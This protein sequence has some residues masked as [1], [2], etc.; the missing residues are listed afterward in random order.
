MQCEAN[1]TQKMNEKTR[2][3]RWKNENF[4]GADGRKWWCRQKT[5]WL[6]NEETKETEIKNIKEEA[7][8]DIE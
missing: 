2:R 6:R 8:R 7:R 1:R 5:H 4:K 3:Q